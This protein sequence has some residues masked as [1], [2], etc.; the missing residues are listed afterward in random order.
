MLRQAPSA[1]L[2]NLR[3]VS[4]PIPNPEVFATFWRFAA[5]RQGI[6]YRRLEEEEGP[7]TQDPILREYRFCNVFRAAD[8]VSQDLIAVAYARP[9]FGADDLF[10]RAVL[11]R[12]FSRPATWRLIEDEFGTLNVAN[13]DP[14]QIGD[15][16][17]AARTEGR[18]LYTGAFILCATDAY[19]HRRKHRNHLALL[20]AMLEAGLPA[21][22]TAAQSLSEVFDLLSNWPL[23]GPFMAYQLAIDLNYTTLIE[24]D[25]NEFTVP[26]P[27]ALRGLRKVF[28]NLG[29]LTPA[30]AVHWLV[31]YQDRADGEF[32]SP[33]PNLFGRPLHAIDAQNLLCEVDKYCRVAF[34]QLT[35]NRTRIKQRFSPDPSPVQLA[36]PPKWG[37][38]LGAWDSTRPGAL[39][40]AV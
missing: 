13:F 9:D 27:G 31:D 6:F 38:D 40:E 21:R 17:E 8:R 33:A 1:P 28:A 25:E 7:W 32:G 12:L 2:E 19:G 37:L 35:S 11:Y 30:Q 24:F 20:S 18:T 5:E 23:I 29:D 14:S 22:V 16:L 3:A 26:G 15:L 39:S 36:F 10:L 34:P 4:E